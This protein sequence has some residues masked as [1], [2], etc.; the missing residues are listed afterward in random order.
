MIGYLKYGENIKDVVTKNL[1]SE[2]LYQSLK[3]IYSLVLLASFPLQMLPVVEIAYFDF[4]VKYVP[5][6]KL[7]FKW[8][9]FTLYLSKKGIF[10]FI[11][12]EL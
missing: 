5:R 3:M 1:P 8:V 6:G 7:G 4:L 10:H 2:P 12:G 9:F 11:W